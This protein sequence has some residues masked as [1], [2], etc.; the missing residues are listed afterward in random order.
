MSAFFHA[1]ELCHHF[2]MKQNVYGYVYDMIRHDV[3]CSVYTCVKKLI[4]IS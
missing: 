3:V 2:F 4:E 1:T